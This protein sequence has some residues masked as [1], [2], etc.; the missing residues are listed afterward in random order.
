MHLHKAVLENKT[1]RERWQWLIQGCDPEL[2]VRFTQFHRANPDV[3]E[4]L[5]RGANVH[6]SQG[7]RRSSVRII[8]NTARWGPESSPDD[9]YAFKVNNNYTSL[10]SRLLIATDPKFANWIEV[11]PMRGQRERWEVG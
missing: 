3:F 8:L 11:R 7:W 9:E 1:Y 4:T 5:R 2:L 6:F 10:Y